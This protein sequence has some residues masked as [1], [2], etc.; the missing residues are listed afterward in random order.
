[1]FI[2]VFEIFEIILDD[3]RKITKFFYIM[4]IFYQPL[5]IPLNVSNIVKIDLEPPSQF[6]NKP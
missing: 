6:Q 1:V 2:A 3:D 5:G 4:Q